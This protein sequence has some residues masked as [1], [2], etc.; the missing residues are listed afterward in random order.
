MPKGLPH[1]RDHDHVIHLQ[2]ASVPPNIRPYKYPYAQKSQIDLMTQ[3]MLEVDIIQQDSQISFSS[4]V[5]MVMKKYGSCCTCPYYRQLNK[6]T[7]KDNFPI[8]IIDELLDELHGPI[9]FTKLDHH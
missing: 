4:L 7:I 8:P 9:F 1:A 6:I 2:L 5:M 3:E